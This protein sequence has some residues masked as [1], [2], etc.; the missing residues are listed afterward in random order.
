VEVVVAA[1][2]QDGEIQ[3]IQEV[4][5]DLDQMV[6]QEIQVREHMLVIL[7]AAADQDKQVVQVT[8]VQQEIQDPVQRVVVQQEIL[9]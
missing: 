1:H 3:E 9:L 2:L 7:V 8:P 4:Q 6:I 5:V